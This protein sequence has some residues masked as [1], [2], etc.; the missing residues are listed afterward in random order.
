MNLNLFEENCVSVDTESSFQAAGKDTC[1]QAIVT[2]TAERDTL[3]QRWRPP[4]ITIDN[5][6]SLFDFHCQK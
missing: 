2:V 6:L 5:N 1:V 4:L 3:T